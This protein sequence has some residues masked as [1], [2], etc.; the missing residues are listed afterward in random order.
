MVNKRI[1]RNKKLNIL[2]G[3]PSKAPKAPKALK[4]SKEN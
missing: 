2:V 4:A 3:L 1:S